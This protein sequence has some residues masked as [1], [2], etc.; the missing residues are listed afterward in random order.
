MSDID[1]EMALQEFESQ[2]TELD[3]PSLRAV[4]GLDVCQ[5]ALALVRQR[6][7]SG[8]PC[9][10]AWLGEVVE[11]LKDV[12]QRARRLPKGG[13]RAPS[14][15]PN[16]FPAEKQFEAVNSAVVKLD[17]TVAAKVKFFL[18]ELEKRSQE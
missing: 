5:G 3:A 4:A 12:L 14:P 13:L 7:A 17:D 15:R 8:E 18:A 10:P 9:D 2:V 1:L 11:T 6:L 16:V